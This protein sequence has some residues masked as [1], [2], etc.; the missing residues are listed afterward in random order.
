M[1]L[2]PSDIDVDHKGRVWVCEVVNYRGRDGQRPE[3]DRILILED[4]NQD[5]VADKQT[6]FYQ[7]RDIDSA[8]GICVLG[9]KVIVSV[10]PN[11]LVF[12]DEDGD[13]KADRKEVLFT[14]VGRPQH[15][16]STH[17]FVFGPDGKLYWNVGNEGHAVHDK[18]GR[19]IVDRAG[20]VVN[21]SRQALSPGD[22]LPL[23]SGRQ[24][25]RD[26]RP[27]LPQQLRSR[28]RLVRHALAVGQR[29]RRQPRGPDQ[30]RDGVRQLRLHRRDDGRRLVVAPDQH[31]GR[32]PA[33]PL[34]PERPGRGAQ[35][36]P[37]R[38]RLA[39]RPLR[40]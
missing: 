4:T 14:K 31:R 11:V 1:L 29:R 24:R 20:N 37:D 28:R 21:D 5:G 17:A 2:S 15:D 35:P 34:A 18:D 6:V 22:G 40:L 3:G 27:Q 39:D 36:A 30:L 8:L 10:A 33:P 7:G 19:P 25:L 16:H 38:R 9:K 26:P 32:D 13:G 12:T 23:Q